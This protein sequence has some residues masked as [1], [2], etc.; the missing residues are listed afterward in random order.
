MKKLYHRCERRGNAKQNDESKRMNEENVL[1]AIYHGG[2]ERDVR[3]RRR[4]KSFISNEEDFEIGTQFN[5]KP[6]KVMLCRVI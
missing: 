2:I 5:R 1:V 6:A 3:E 4:I